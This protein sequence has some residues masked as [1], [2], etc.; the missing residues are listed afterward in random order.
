MSRMRVIRAGLAIALATG[1]LAACADIP[2]SGPTNRVEGE[3]ESEEDLVQVEPAGPAPGA[4]PTETVTGFIDAMQASPPTTEF[5]KQ[6]LTKEAAAAWDPF[7]EVVVYEGFQPTSTPVGQRVDL[8]VRRQATLNARGAYRA[9]PT[10][11]AFDVHHY[12]LRQEA[13]ECGTT[14]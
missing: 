10:S 13:G 9:V 5:A 4:S 7:E 12:V 3:I 8:K 2:D 1:V 14:T 6:F 11:A